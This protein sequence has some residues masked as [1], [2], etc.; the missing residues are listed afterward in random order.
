MR[1]ASGAA[2]LPR[3]PPLPARA[4]AST[5]CDAPRTAP[6][7]RGPIHSDDREASAAPPRRRASTERIV[8]EAR[9][10]KNGPRSAD[11]R[12]RSSRRSTAASAASRRSSIGSSPRLARSPNDFEIVL[13]NDASSGSLLG[14]DR[15]GGSEREPRVVGVDLS[16][17]FGQH[18]AIRAGLEWARGEWVV[19]M[20]CDLQDRPEEIP[21]LV[22]E[23]ARARPRRGPRAARFS[24]QFGAL[25]ALVVVAL[26]RRARLFDRDPAGQLDREFRRLPTPAHRRGAPARSARRVLSDDGA[27][28]RF[29][30]GHARR[31]ARRARGGRVDLRL[32]AP[33]CAW[34]PTQS[35]PRA[36][37]RC[38]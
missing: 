26:L 14:G 11:R 33:R 36:I 12:S 6:S 16:R 9:R 32:R 4:A 10:T 27:P 20:D 29:P 25:E 37:S 24:K 2:R 21:R 23:R 8:P 28:G 17:N 31:R 22:G 19:V 7:T 1:R 5:P 35:S 30:A 3:D 38:A 15:G 34:R 13:V 18:P